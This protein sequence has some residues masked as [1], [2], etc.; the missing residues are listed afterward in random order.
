[1]KGFYVV[2]DALGAA[3]GIIQ[4]AMHYVD[5]VCAIPECAR[6][7]IEQ[8]HEIQFHPMFQQ[9]MLWRQVEAEL[10]AGK[11]RDTL[12]VA[13]R[14]M[15]DPIFFSREFGVNFDEKAVLSLAHYQ[16]VFLCVTAGIEASHLYDTRELERRNSL[17]RRIRSTLA[18]LSID[19]IELGGS[20]N[21][22]LLTFREAIPVCQGSFRF[23]QSISKILACDC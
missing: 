13:D 16:R 19:F 20:T 12:I 22:R 3:R 18:E 9:I 23:H 15:I 10:V 2:G 4:A 8:A 5:G 11:S 6:N 21:E 17:E 1:V 14:G 7:T